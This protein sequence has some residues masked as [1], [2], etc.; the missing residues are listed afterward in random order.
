[1]SQA[2]AEYIKS[3]PT[4]DVDKREHHGVNGV[5]DTNS[6]W[7]AAASNMLAAA[8]YGSGSEV[9]DRADDIYEDMNEHFGNQSC[10]WATRLL[11]GG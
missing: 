5:R 8:G 11:R 4:P 1:M 6:C 7:M 3:V 10:G 2:D 9:Q